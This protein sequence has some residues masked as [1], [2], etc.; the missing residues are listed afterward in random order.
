MFP[1]R[2]PMPMYNPQPALPE[3]SPS[4]VRIVNNNDFLIEDRYDGELFSFPHGEKITVPYIVAMHIFGLGQAA[5]EQLMYCVRRFGWHTGTVDG[6]D[7]AKK[8]FAKVSISPVF[9]RLVEVPPEPDYP[10]AKPAKAG[11]RHEIEDR[12]A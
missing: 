1:G 8:K 2:M 3:G 4:H 10:D 7:T 6:M 9:M 12:S 11:K 5:Q